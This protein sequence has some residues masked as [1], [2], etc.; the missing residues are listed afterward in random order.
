V[1]AVSGPPIDSATAADSSLR[2]FIR[3]TGR[4][5][6]IGA[7]VGDLAGGPVVT[8]RVPDIRLA[9]GYTARVLEVAD[10]GNVLRASLT[11]YAL[12]VPP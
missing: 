12:S 7:V 3:R 10:R 6:I 11:G 4:S 2:V 9:A 1:F 8:L 5:T